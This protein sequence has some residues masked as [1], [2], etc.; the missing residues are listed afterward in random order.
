MKPPLRV[1]YAVFYKLAL[2]AII[3]L[4][5]WLIFWFIP[6]AAKRWGLSSQSDS[7]FSLV[8]MALLIFL[9]P[10]LL[11][12]TCIFG[13]IFGFSWINSD[14]AN[15]ER[16]WY[17]NRQVEEKRRREAYQA[18]QQVRQEAEKLKRRQEKEAEEERRRERV[19]EEERKKELENDIKLQTEAAN[20]KLELE[21][22]ALK[23]KNDV[24]VHLTDKQIEQIALKAFR[25][26]STLPK[27]EQDEAWLEWE[28]ALSGEYDRYVE[29]EIME[30]V[31][32]LRGEE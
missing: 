10:F 13:S 8:S 27:R 9:V 22:L 16:E 5:V 31:N 29:S 12:A 20:Q 17:A 14:L 18:T 6:G 32:E 30:R 15:F 1:K 23:A 21:A 7:L 24:A 25:R 3:A 2:L 4:G 19:A 28:D 11:G 26:I